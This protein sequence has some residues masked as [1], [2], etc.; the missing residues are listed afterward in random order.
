MTTGRVTVAKQVRK[1]K[2][3][4]DSLDDHSSDSD[5]DVIT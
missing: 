3:R 2:D 4:K 5:D 1:L